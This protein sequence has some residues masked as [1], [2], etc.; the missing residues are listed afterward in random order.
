METFVRPLF[1]ITLDQAVE[2]YGLGDG[3]KARIADMLDGKERRT[4]DGRVVYFAS[5][6][7]RVL[8]WVRAA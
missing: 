5:D 4:P 3:D 1:V 8:R 2:L 7:E 6:I